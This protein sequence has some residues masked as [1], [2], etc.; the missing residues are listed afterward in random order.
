MSFFYSQI[1]VVIEVACSFEYFGENV[2][3]NEGVSFKHRERHYESIRIRDS[4]SLGG[5]GEFK[6]LLSQ[7]TRSNYH[8]GITKSIYYQNIF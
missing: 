7:N 2:W 4:S 6:P 5:Y 3:L 8:T 1:P